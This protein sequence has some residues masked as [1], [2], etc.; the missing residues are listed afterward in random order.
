MTTAIATSFVQMYHDAVGRHLTAPTD[1]EVRNFGDAI[2][3][4]YHHDLLAAVDATDVFARPDLSE[5]I[6]EMTDAQ[7]RVDAEDLTHAIVARWLPGAVRLAS[8]VAMSTYND[9]MARALVTTPD[10]AFNL[11]QV[12]G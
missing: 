12:A 6:A 1:N 8:L 7:G 5:L 9:E 2:V 4:Q 3:E 11:M 10:E